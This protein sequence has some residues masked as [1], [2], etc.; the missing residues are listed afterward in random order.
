MQGDCNRPERF[1]DEPCPLDTGEYADCSECE[2]FTPY[3][4]DAKT[5]RDY[6]GYRDVS[7]HWRID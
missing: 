6:G 3:G 7:G 2:W 4:V 5:Y 1:D